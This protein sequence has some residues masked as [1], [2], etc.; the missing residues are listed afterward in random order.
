MKQKLHFYKRGFAL[1]LAVALVLTTFNVRMLTANASK[2]P[3]DISLTIPFGA[4]ANYQDSGAINVVWGDAGFDSYCVTISGKDTT[5]S[6][7]Q[8][9]PGQ[10][11]GA[12]DYECASGSYEAGK[13]Y[14]VEIQGEQDG[15]YSPAASVEVKIPGG[16]TTEGDSGEN[17]ETDVKAPIA[18]SG[19]VGGYWETDDIN[20]G[21]IKVEWGAGFGDGGTPT[22][23]IVSIDGKEV[24]T[25]TAV[26]AYFYDNNYTAGEHTVSIIAENTA[27]KSPAAEIKFTLTEE[28]AGV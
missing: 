26:A 8:E 28:Q 12:H 4:V 22:Q 25:E 9:Y 27:G 6:Y 1:M 11:L 20:K 17:P 24:G 19:L 15:S 14:L 7:T 16:E 10:S 23:W 2:T 5:T 3:E 21:K 13:T 18:P